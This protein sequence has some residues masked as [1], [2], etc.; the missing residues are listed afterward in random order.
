MHHKVLGAGAF[1]QVRKATHKS[2]GEIRAVKMID[3]LVLDEEEQVRLKYEI[4]I[5]KNL[6]HPNIVKLY[7]VYESKSLIYLVT[8]LCDGCELFDEISKRDHFSEVE[9]AVVLK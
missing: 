9:A 1:G 8:E 4:D 3:K 6:T 5:L 2:S 7:E